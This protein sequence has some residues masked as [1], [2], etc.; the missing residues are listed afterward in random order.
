ME[1]GLSPLGGRLDLPLFAFSV[2]LGE[3]L[4]KGMKSRPEEIGFVFQR[5]FFILRRG[6]GVAESPA[7]PPGK[8]RGMVLVSPAPSAAH[9]GK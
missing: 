8:P 3:V 2:K 1:K 5:L 4:L 7:L 6:R 9:P